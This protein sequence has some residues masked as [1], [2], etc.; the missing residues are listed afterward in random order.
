VTRA[1][2]EFILGND[3]ELIAPLVGYLEAGLTR[4]KLCDETGLI[5]VAVALREALV[6]A[7]EHGNLEAS[8]ALREHGQGEPYRDLLKA[9]R[10]QEPYFNRRVHVSANE[11]PAE[12]IYTV[13]DEGPGF[14]PS[15]LPDPTDPA[16]LEKVHGRGILL[17]RTFMD[18]V[19]HHSNGREIT[20]TKRR[21]ATASV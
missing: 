17:I 20:M 11:S 2:T 5:R 16:N 18:E 14:D 9:R 3:P 12:A 19:Q 10:S 13:R 15:N 6:N 7:M 8:S 1:E 21:D 4:M